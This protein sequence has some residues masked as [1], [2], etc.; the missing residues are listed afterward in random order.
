[1]ADTVAALSHDSDFNDSLHHYHHD[2]TSNLLHNISH[3]TPVD[4]VLYR[5]M[6]SARTTD[7]QIEY[8]V[9]KEL[10]QFYIKQNELIDQYTHMNHITALHHMTDS[11]QLNR[12]IADNQSIHK[13]KVN[14]VKFV[15][16]LSFY[17]TFIIIALKAY[18]AARSASIAVISICVDSGLDLI[19][20]GILLYSNKI[21]Q[22]VDLYKYPSGRSRVEPVSIVVF[23]CIMG[24][25][26]I[27]LLIESVQKLANDLTTTP[28]I[29]HIDYV[30][31]LLIVVVVAIQLC[32]YIYCRIVAS[33]TDQSSSV[34][35]I[36]NDHIND[37][38]IN[39][40]GGIPAIIAGYYTSLYWLDP[41]GGIMLSLYIAFRW[42]KTCIQQLPQLI[43]KSADPN[44]LKKLTYL[45]MTHNDVIVHV[46]TVLAYYIGPK[47][48][49]EIHIVLPADLSLREAHDIGESLEC[50]VECIDD[51]EMAFVHL[52]YEV[53]HK[54]EHGRGK[55]KELIHEQIIDD[56]H[57][58]TELTSI[59]LV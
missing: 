56:D 59:Q 20:Q 15:L 4:T 17:M 34:I 32:E 48:Q 5:K 8:I 42:S 27:I 39:L 7:K 38:C 9:S 10:Q 23:S 47:L 16:N 25:A 18:T 58:S 50:T 53:S 44:T 43:G 28:S 3:L 35:A 33:Q 6:V 30:V 19:S 51:I 11:K 24:M 14:K 45:S 57:N 41:M 37:V 54:P 36:G 21:K 29:V 13:I 49:V 12:H 31:I 2:S 22:N 26:A 1:M 40:L 52:D 55:Q 46:D